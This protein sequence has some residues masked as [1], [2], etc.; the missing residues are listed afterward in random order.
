MPIVKTE[1]VP[2]QELT[3]NEKCGE[4][5]GNPRTI[6]C[7]QRPLEWTDYEGDDQPSAHTVHTRMGSP[8]SIDMLEKE[9][10]GF[11]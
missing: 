8:K 2:Y 3:T 6:K 4:M 5:I 1:M 11:R 10:S 9:E 7:Y